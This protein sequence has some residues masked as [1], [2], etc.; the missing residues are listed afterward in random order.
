MDPVHAQCTNLSKFV[1]FE[2]LK[3]ESFI[4]YKTMR[5]FNQNHSLSKSS[6]FPS[7]FQAVVKMS[8]TSIN[9][10]KTAEI[11]DLAWA[12]NT[13]YVFF[14]ICALGH[15]NKKKLNF[16]FFAAPPRCMIIICK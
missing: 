8:K 15:T 1:L 5:N 12:N 9:V 4:N 11:L 10:E 7:H 6:Q 13:L 2:S 14:E 16:E 3:I